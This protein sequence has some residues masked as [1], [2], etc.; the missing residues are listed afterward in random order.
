MN[1]HVDALVGIYN[2]EGSLAG[3]IRYLWSKL[4]GQGRCALCDITHRG[5]RQKP[6]FQACLEDIAIPF[7]LLPLDELGA[8]LTELT[9]GQ[10]PCI[11]ARRGRTHSILLDA[12]ALTD[13]DG[14]VGRFRKRLEQALGQTDP[15][16]NEIRGPLGSPGPETH[17]PGCFARVGVSAPR[18]KPNTDRIE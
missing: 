5:V 9:T 16:A 2:A 7:E 15:S 11:L 18:E 8:E 12:S 13:C 17:D 14:D 10:V 6:A 4:R 3:E 1:S